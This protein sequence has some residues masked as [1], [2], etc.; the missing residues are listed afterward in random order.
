M[1]PLSKTAKPLRRIFSRYEASDYKGVYEEYERKK[2]KR[3]AALVERTP[4]TWIH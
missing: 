3:N 2:A 1:L 4:A